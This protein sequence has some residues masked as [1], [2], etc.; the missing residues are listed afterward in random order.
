[1][2]YQFTPKSEKD[3]SSGFENLPPGEYPFTV[4]ES[5]I[6]KSKSAKNPDRPFIKIKIAVHGDG[7]D[8]HIFDQFADWFSEWKLKHFCETT[9]LRDEYCLG[10]LSPELS[11]WK[12][13]QGY[14]RIKIKP[15]QG[16]YEANNEVHDYLPDEEQKIESMKPEAK[17]DPNTAK[18][19]MAKVKAAAGMEAEEDDGIP[20]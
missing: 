9:N 5:A 7:V 13:R 8:R 1:M 19:E 3:L 16:E 12:D 10:A 6:V 18:R 20:F 14:C 11:A 4:L 15:A 2:A 17:V